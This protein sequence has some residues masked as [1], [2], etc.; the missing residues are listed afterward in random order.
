MEFKEELHWILDKKVKKPGV[1]WDEE[2][3]RENIDFVHS[4]GL[5]CDS[6]GWCQL[7]LSNPRTGEI[8]DAIAEFCQKNG[9]RARGWYHLYYI[10]PQAQWFELV[11]RDFQ[12][13]T[14]AGKEEFA[15][16]GCIQVIRA[17]R[18]T[19]SGP[20]SDWGR[21]SYVPERF[22][23]ACQQVPE[24]DFC[25]VKDVGKY[26]AEQYFAIYPRQTVPHIGVDWK[27]R[28]NSSGETRLCGWDYQAQE[29]PIAEAMGRWLPRV[30]QLFYDRTI[31]LQDCYLSQDMPENGM[32]WAH[33]ADGREP[34]Y[35]RSQI[36]LHRDL[37]RELLQKRAILPKDLRPAYVTDTLP[38][39]YTRI[40][41]TAPAR[42]PAEFLASH[43]EQYEELKRN[44]RP[45]RQ[46]QE[47]EVL[48]LLRRGRKDR[49]EDFCKPL[50][51]VKAEALGD[52]PYAPL[53]PVYRITNGGVLS[54]ECEYQLLP[55]EMALTENGEFFQNLAR[56]ELLEEKPDA[57]VI[58]QCPDGDK[59][60][61]CSDGGV[62]RFSHEAPEV[63]AQWPTLHQFLFDALTE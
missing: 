33:Y 38:A 50:P 15:D 6:V 27:M 36:L 55:Y 39:G 5:K 58:A 41:A 61:L 43:W 52:T 30:A 2:A 3:A 12:D 20:K 23:D 13:N 19:G 31:R 1:I 16:G 22:R 11:T 14:M 59:V 10:D 4:L 7:D 28:R 25:W 34:F 21:R 37:A 48:T 51:K 24:V 42:P 17:F 29:A 9:F 60:L 53:I 32:A 62:I 49:P 63:V 8:F 54:Q 26:A 18:E 35:R 57:V 46:V 56:E 44:P 47:K 45:V 40:D